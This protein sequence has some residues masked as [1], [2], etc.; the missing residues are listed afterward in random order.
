MPRCAA[1]ILLFAAACLTGSAQSVPFIDQPLVPTAIKDGGPG[2]TLTVNGGGFVAQS[3]V[4][5]NGSPVATTYVS[6][7]KLTAQIPASKIASPETAVISVSSGA[8]LVSSGVFLQVEATRPAV[9]FTASSVSAV[10][11]Q[12]L[13]FG[14]FNGDG[15]QDLVTRLSNDT[16]EVLLGNGDGTFQSPI[17]LPTVVSQLNQMLAVDINGDGNLDLVVLSDRIGESSVFLGNGNGTFQGPQTLPVGD[18]GAVFAAASDFNGDGKLDLVSYED[19]VGIL[20]LL[21]NGDGTFTAGPVL[22]STAVAGGLMVGDLNGDGFPDIAVYTSTPAGVSIFLNDGSGGM[23]EGQTLPSAAT[24]TPFV[25]A[26]LNG[27]GII[28]IATVS[29]SR[30][31]VDIYLGNGDGTFQST[32][33]YSTGASLE[34]VV[35][36]GDFNGDGKLDLIVPAEQGSPTE[37]F[38]LLLGNGDGTFQIAPAYLGASG[39]DELAADFNNDGE[40][41][42]AAVGSGPKIELV[43]QTSVLATPTGLAFPTVPV[44]TI[45][46]PLS[47]KVSNVSSAPLAIS[48]LHLMGQNA[49]AFSFATNLCSGTVLASGASCSFSVLFAP[50]TP[51]TIAASVIIS[52]NARVNPQA[53]PLEGTAS[54][55]GVSPLSLGF[56]TVKVENASAGQVV[57]ITNM[58][59]LTAY[60]EISVGGADPQDFLVESTCISDVL[61]PGTGCSLFVRFIPT[62]SGARTATLVINDAATNVPVSVSLSGTGS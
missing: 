30:A 4:L 59:T 60:V 3:V 57:A 5:W 12:Q 37:G 45:S 29:S 16:I 49:A 20:L 61:Q 52:D 35:L 25:L 39:F 54:E 56:G 26:D 23:T 7:R 11:P 55:I 27:D 17:V 44:T 13:A 22:G 2:F 42:L 48:G 33:S 32:A 24:L 1:L 51:G 46:Q 58:G 53:V 9:A 41:D 62:V 10:D 21:G 38:S 31:S 18:N 14:D 50:T 15:K 36:A 28:D 40:L 43:L 19:F 47:A 8:K 6:S 34:G